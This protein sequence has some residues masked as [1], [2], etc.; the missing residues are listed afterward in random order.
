MGISWG[1]ILAGP[2][3]QI[4]FFWRPEGQALQVILTSSRV[5]KN[6]SSF[7]WVKWVAFSRVWRGTQWLQMDPN[8]ETFLW[9]GGVRWVCIE[10]YQN[11]RAWTKVAWKKAWNIQAHRQGD[12]R[13]HKLYEYAVC[14]IEILFRSPQKKGTWHYHF[15][16]TDIS[17]VLLT[18][19]WSSTTT[20]NSD[21]VSSDSCLLPKQV[22]ENWKQHASKI[23]SPP[24]R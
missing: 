8:L 16:E 3:N 4:C 14:V 5:C 17:S 18:T 24:W 21:Q 13:K 11:D 23:E 10:I 19:T 15:E 20:S 6:F 2:L 7:S 12:Y 1:W 9:F 22:C